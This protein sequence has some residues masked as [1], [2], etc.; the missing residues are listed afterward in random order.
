MAQTYNQLV[1]RYHDQTFQDQ[2]LWSVLFLIRYI[3][4]ESPTTPNHTK[5]VW[6]ANAAMT[7]P[8]ETALKMSAYAISDPNCTGDVAPTDVQVE[9][10]VEALVNRYTQ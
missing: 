6:W 2:I 4:D 10:A 7:N 8:S 3:N 9:A 5:R 1:A